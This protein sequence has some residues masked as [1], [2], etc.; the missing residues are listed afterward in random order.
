MYLYVLIN[1]LVCILAFYVI[2]ACKNEILLKIKRF[3]S[4][5]NVNRKIAKKT[6]SVF[7][8]N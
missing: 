2:F 1:Y 6:I 8:F 5:S 4:E 3:S 7:V